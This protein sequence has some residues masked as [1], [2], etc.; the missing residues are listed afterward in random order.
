[1]TGGRAKSWLALMLVAAA[2]CTTAPAGAHR[3]DAAFLSLVEL[4]P[5]RF[6]LKWQAGSS[7]L[8]QLTEPALF[9]APCRIEE[10]FLECGEQGLAGTIEFPWLSGSLTHLL[11]DIEWL[12]HSHLVR[13]ISSSAPRL[14]VYH[15]SSTR[16]WSA[17]SAVVKD[18]VALGIEHIWTGLDHLLFVCAL[19]L[20][21]GKRRL[22]GTVTAFTLA[23]SASLALTVLGWLSLPSPP[24]EATIA[25]SIVLICAEGLRSQDSLTAKAPWAVAGVF[26]LL[27][28][29]GFAS[30]LLEIGLPEAHLPLALVCFN[31]GVEVGQLAVVAAVLALGLLLARLG[32]QQASQRLGLYYGMGSVAAAWSLERVAA[33]LG[34]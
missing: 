3:V 33:L 8:E 13:S 31:A 30:A 29:L 5:G 20:L 34:Y 22:L 23:H 21:V 19:T 14:A 9:P 16:D 6:A 17:Q 2:E 10:S 26:G 7:S 15:A 32:L 11:V 1:M 4:A 24:V 25:L 27:H 12:D 28:G 18:Y